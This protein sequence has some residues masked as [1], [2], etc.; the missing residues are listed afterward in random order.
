MSSKKRVFKQDRDIQVILGTVLR[1]GVI[2]S[3]I[4]VFI[5]GIIYLLNSRT[6]IVDY[7]VFNLDETRFSSVVSVL[8][9]LVQLNGR[10]IV[11]SGILLLIF[12]PVLRVAFSIFGFL[13]ERDYLYVLIGT[14]VLAVILFSLSHKLVG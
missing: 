8:S 13:I 5:G 11:Q 14:F 1:T 4:I 10:A 12:T 6:E 2:F 7:S 3:M 9:G